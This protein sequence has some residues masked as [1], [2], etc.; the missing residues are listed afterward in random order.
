[1]ISSGYSPATAKKQDPV[2]FHA[3]VINFLPA[4]LLLTAWFSCMCRYLCASLAICRCL[5]LLPRGRPSSVDFKIREM[6]NSVLPRHFL[7]SLWSKI[8]LKRERCLNFYQSEVRIWIW[9]EFTLHDLSVFFSHPWVAPLRHQKWLQ[10]RKGEE[11]IF[12]ER[13]LSALYM[14]FI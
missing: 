12:V 8:A 14:L 5:S 4:A 1:M 6:W 13:V 2:R 3:V 7:C 9:G 11:L 10:A